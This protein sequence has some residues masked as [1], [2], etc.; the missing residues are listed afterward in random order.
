MSIGAIILLAVGAL[1]YFGIADRILDRLYLNDKMA[2][3]IIAAI[4]AGSFFDLTLSQSPLI[5]I[6]VGGAI[7]PVLLAAYVLSRADSAREWIRTIIAILL[8]GAAIYGISI[9]F[10][11]FGHGRDIIDPMYIYA[12]VGGLI[13]YI[14][15]RSRK[16]SY[17]AGTLGFLFYNLINVWRVLSG[18]INSQVMIGGAGA[19]DNI[20]IAG[21]FAVLLAELIGESRERI[22]GGPVKGNNLPGE[23]RGDNNDE[24]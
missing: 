2:L 17:I 11:D 9:L 3:V 5:T 18:Q 10:S 7:I 14:L 21:I 6:N 15:G 4:I 22:Q 8:T 1:V 24:N 16:G 13:A 23:N 12:I 19:F 20:V